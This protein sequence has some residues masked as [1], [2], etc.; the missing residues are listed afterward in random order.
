MKKQILAVFLA[1]A[2]LL[3][4]GGGI[5]PAALRGDT[6]E[7]PVQQPILQPTQ[8]PEQE[9]DP[10]PTPQPTQQPAPVDP[11]GE[12]VILFTGD[13]HCAVDEGLGCAGRRRRGD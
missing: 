1:A 11:S 6:D 9:N 5:L 2:M 12:G 10:E 7:R 4:T 3:T 8:Q 13:V